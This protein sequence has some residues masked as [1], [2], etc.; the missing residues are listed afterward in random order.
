MSFPVEQSE[1]MMERFQEFLRFE[2]VSDLG[3]TNGAYRAC[4]DFLKA[5]LESIGVFRVF[6]LEESPANS[7]VVVAH[8]KGKDSTLPVLLWNSHYDVVPADMAK[9][10]L[11]PFEAIRK[12]GKIYGRGAQDMKC[13]C[14]QYIEALRILLGS[15]GGSSL[16]PERDVYLTYVPD[17]ETG[18]AGMAAFLDSELYRSLPGIALA[19]DEGLAST[20]DSMDVFYGERLPWWVKVTANG[21]TGHGSRF[22]ENTAVEQLLELTTKAMHFRNGQRD[23][24]QMD[25][26]EN[27]TH[28]VVAASKNA[29]R[30]T[31][32]DVTS[33]NITAL[34]A[35]VKAGDTFVLNVVPPVASCM[36]DIRISPNMDPMEVRGLLDQWCQECSRTEGTVSWSFVHSNNSATTHATTST[37]RTVNP[38]YALVADTLDKEMGISLTPQVFPAA[39]DSRFLRALGIRALGFSPMRNTEI[40]LH[41]H[42]EYILES[43]YLEGIEVYVKLFR[44]LVAFQETS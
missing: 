22:I 5:Q 28:A 20:T 7:P 2:T 39:T 31:L 6:E 40:M 3:P 38:W 25:S 23:L 18:G 27:C 10:T 36:M 42:D 41:E 32:G 33:L 17:E 30:K 44:A 8:W 16:V 13:V 24:L 21:P 19:L 29:K 9:W 1:A 34:Q 4:A 43:N 15:N 35:G 11:P 14:M 12:D 37:D 26:H